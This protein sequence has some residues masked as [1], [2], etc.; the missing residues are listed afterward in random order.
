MGRIR[1]R[2]AEA[3]PA[4]APTPPD[5]HPGLME[6]DGVENATT[7]YMVVAQRPQRLPERAT[8]AMAVRVGA[9]KVLLD[10]EGTRASSFFKAG[11]VRLAC[12]RHPRPAI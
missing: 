5:P 1:G 2:E 12:W 4:L 10:P 8:V 9:C 3:A 11:G 7:S 6:G